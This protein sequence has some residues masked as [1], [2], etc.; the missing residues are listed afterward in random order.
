MQ[1]GF[2]VPTPLAYFALLVSSDEHFPLLEAAVAL[3]QD[4]YPELDVQQVLGEVDQM[5][6]RLKRRL[7]AD[8]TPLAKLRILNQFF[9]HDLGFSG[10]INNYYD[11]DNSYL[12]AVLHT[13][14][15]IP[16]SLA[17]LW[18]ELAQGLN[19]NARGVAFPGHFMVKVNLPKGQVVIDPFTGQSLS[20]EDLSER[21][22][23]FKHLAELPESDMAQD[24]IPLGLYLQSAKP[25]DIITRMLYNLKEVHKTAEDWQRMIPVQ[26]RLIAL[27]ADAWSE[28]RDRG[29]AF[30]ELGKATP[31]VRDF[32]V[33]L[34]NVADAPDVKAIA[35]RAQELRRAVI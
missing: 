15:G 14:R 5:L 3:A 19:L 24:D 12:H 8:S 7:P 30:A 32:D 16:I 26:D 34:Q 27:N 6:A 29:L 2:D 11:P 21:L 33:Y 1:L 35:L 22:M 20:R 23:P 18:L 4:E 31:A 25:R 28:Y 17:V 13:R 9:Y 10:N